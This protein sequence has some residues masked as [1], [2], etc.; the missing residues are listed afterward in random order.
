MELIANKLLANEIVNIF[1]FLTKSIPIVI[2]PYTNH[3]QI[4]FISQKDYLYIYR[5]S[6]N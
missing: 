5:N 6:L 2:D 3:P 1:K 4:S